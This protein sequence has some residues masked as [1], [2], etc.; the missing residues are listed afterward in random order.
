[1]GYFT[2]IEARADVTGDGKSH[3]FISRMRLMQPVDFHTLA[4]FAGNQFTLVR[5][6]PEL[7]HC[8]SL[9]LLFL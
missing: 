8:K 2:L 3:W 5:G 9:S 7:G 1:M 6:T 4:Q